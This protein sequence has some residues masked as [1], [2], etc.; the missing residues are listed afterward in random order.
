MRG[1]GKERPMTASPSWAR[2][3]DVLTSC[4][5]KLVE[6]YRQALREDHGDYDWSVLVRSAEL[7]Q[8]NEE[9]PPQTLLERVR[10]G[11]HGQDEA[12]LR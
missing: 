10:Q 1:E 4:L 9:I 2:F 6:V 12:L 7:G 8:V 3:Q 11:T 5:E